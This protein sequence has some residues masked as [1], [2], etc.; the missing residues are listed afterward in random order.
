MPHTRISAIIRVFIHS[1]LIMKILW[2]YEQKIQKPEDSCL[3]QQ[4]LHWPPQKLTQ[5]RMMSVKMS[6]EQFYLQ[7]SNLLLNI[8]T[9]QWCLHQESLKHSWYWH[10]FWMTHMKSKL[11][12]INLGTDK[13]LEHI[14]CEVIV[15]Y[16][17]VHVFVKCTHPCVSFNEAAC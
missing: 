9:L 4:L 5:H 3:Q 1:L 15:L 16:D 8:L 10:M 7:H 14:C 6:F 2:L 13:C 17:N 11:K 12:Y